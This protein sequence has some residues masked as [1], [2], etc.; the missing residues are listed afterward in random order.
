MSKDNVDL[1]CD[2][3]E[4]AGLFERTQS[5]SDFLQK[6][7]SIIA[8]HMKAAVCSVYLFDDETQEVVLRATQGLNPDV[9]GKTRL[10]LGEG[11]VGQALAEFRAIREAKGSQNPHFKLIQGLQ[12]EQYN[13]FLA[14]PLVRGLTRVGVITVQDPVPNYFSENDEKALRAIAAQLASTI[15][16][17]K[18]LMNLHSTTAYAGG[19]APVVE[20]ELKFVK[21]GVA[22]GG[23]A[24]GRAAIMGH[25]DIHEF[26]QAKSAH[27]MADFERA[28]AKTENQLEDLQRQLAERMA[29]V[30]SLIFNAHLL[31]LKDSEF[32]GMMMRRIKLVLPAPEG[33]VRN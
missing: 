1:I 10:K 5:L 7:V 33:P 15:E 17:A 19:K 9:V 14:A 32:S 26:S 16:N 29:D 31:M 28:L 27:S 30:A 12:E 20:G 24:Y 11:I 13:A 8:Y 18:L 21:G 4:L 25:L 3:G 23:L 22:S 2:I 6:V